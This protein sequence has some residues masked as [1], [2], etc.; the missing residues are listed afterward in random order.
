MIWEWTG[1]AVTPPATIE[2]E[3]VTL[4]GTLAFL[5]YDAPQLA[6]QGAPV[7]VLTYWRV[8]ERPSRPLS[9]MLHLTDA[10]G[11]P[12]ATGDGLGVPVEQWQPDDMIVQRHVLTIP[13]DALLTG[14][15]LRGGAYWLDDMTRLMAGADDSIVLAFI[16][17]EQ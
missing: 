3:D 5:G 12:I 9:L 6:R 10:N 13:V 14:Y 15:Q 1:R 11:V 7:D 16:E 4:D 2:Q 8:V 17:I